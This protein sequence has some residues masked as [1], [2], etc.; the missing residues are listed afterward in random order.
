M[1]PEQALSKYTY[2]S[3]SHCSFANKL[4]ARECKNLNEIS[5]LEWNWIERNGIYQDGRNFDWNWKMRLNGFAVRLREWNTNWEQEKEGRKQFRPNCMVSFIFKFHILNTN[6]CF[7]CSQQSRYPSNV[8]GIVGR[9]STY[10]EFS[11]NHCG[12]NKLSSLDIFYS[13]NRR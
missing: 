1:L 9:N 3:Q 11:L 2:Y 4:I 5:K 6:E 13:T 7:Y 12:V 8:G 10:I